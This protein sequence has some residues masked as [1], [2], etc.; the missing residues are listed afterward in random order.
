MHIKDQDDEET[1]QAS[2][3]L[4]YLQVN[5]SRDIFSGTLSFEK[6]AGILE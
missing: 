4:K 5:G 6:Y 3:F 2:I 1:N